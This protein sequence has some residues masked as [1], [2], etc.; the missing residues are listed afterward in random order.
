MIK[1]K[2][3]NIRLLYKVY[4][5]ECLSNDWD[6]KIDNPPVSYNVFKMQLKKEQKRGDT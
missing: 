6:E 2:E 1:M 4:L 3:E 5:L